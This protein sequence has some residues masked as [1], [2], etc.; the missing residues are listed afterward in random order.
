L[1]LAGVAPSDKKAA[2]AWLRE[3]IELAQSM[4]RAVKQRPL[5]VDHNAPLADIEK[6][7]K[8]SPGKLSG[9]AGIQSPG[10]HFGVLAF[11]GLYIIAAKDL[12]RANT[13]QGVWANTMWC[14]FPSVVG[15]RT[16]AAT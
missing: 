10:T 8:S 13:P 11:L 3:A 7:A 1:R 4:Y 9:C 2:E 14:S 5:P 15:W 16:E 6:A 12:I